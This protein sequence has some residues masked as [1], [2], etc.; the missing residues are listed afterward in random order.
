[1]G[2][3]TALPPMEGET[4]AVLCSRSPPAGKITLLHTFCSSSNCADGGMPLFPPHQGTDGNFY[5]GTNA[6][7][8][9]LERVGVVY[10]LTLLERTK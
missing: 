6:G 3:F 8:T 5:G 4:T 7:G 1:M 9:A 10:K 2:I